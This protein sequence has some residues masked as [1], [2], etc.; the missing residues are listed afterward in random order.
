MRAQLDELLAADPD[1]E[2]AF[3]VAHNPVSQEPPNP[4]NLVL[5]TDPEAEKV[6]DLANALYNHMLRFLAQS[7][8][9]DRDGAEHKRNFV[10]IARELM[11]ILTPVCEYLASLPAGPENPGVNAGMTFT[12]LRDVARVPDGHGEMRMLG[13]RLTEMAAQAE[14]I[15]PDG[16]ELDGIADVLRVMASKIVIPGARPVPPKH[17]AHDDRPK[18]HPSET[19]EHVIGREEGADMI[20]SFDTSRC[21]HARF[22][23]LGA[24]TVFLS[25]VEGRWLFPDNMK[26]A[27][28]RGICH[29]CPSGAISYEPKGDTPPEPA[30]QVNIVKIREDGPYAF[31]APISIDGKEIGYRATL[32]R[33]GASKNKPFCDGSHKHIGFKATGEPETRPSEPLAVRDG[34]LEITPL[35]NGP[36]QIT[37]NLEVCAGTGRNVDRVT[38]ARLCRCGAS[39]TKPFCDNTHLKIGF[40]SD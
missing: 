13:E 3:P 16:H 9:R 40:K 36:L 4:D 37:G 14:R 38:T 5:I 21:I 19:E 8:G 15:F 18:P 35:P 24:P 32:C 20:L 26:T 27:D 22:C 34:P 11:T 7:Y 17:E 28:L 2:P 23:V 6:L 25:G 39:K 12:M 29:N 10:T 33:C 1:F 30:P 31:R